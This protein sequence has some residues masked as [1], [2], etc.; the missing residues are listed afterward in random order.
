MKSSIKFV[1]LLQTQFSSIVS[2]Y[3]FFSQQ[4]IYTR[5]EAHKWMLKIFRIFMFTYVI[6]NPNKTNLIDSTFNP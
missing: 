4:N 6:V 5:T 1:L 3:V 2:D